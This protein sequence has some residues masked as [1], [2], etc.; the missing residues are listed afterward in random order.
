MAT[1]SSLP[2]KG[3]AGQITF[4]VACL[5]ALIWF[6]S[7]YV[8][9]V[10]NIPLG[11]DEYFQIHSASQ[12]ITFS[13]LSLTRIGDQADGRLRSWGSGRV[14]PNVAGARTWAQ[15][16]IGDAEFQ[17]ENPGKPF[18]TASFNCSL[19]TSDGTYRGIFS[20]RAFPYWAFVLPLMLFA[21]YFF[22]REYRNSAPALPLPRQKKQ[23]K[24]K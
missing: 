7:V 10:I 21:G 4:V 15:L 14:R 22:Y 9:N 24:K 1:E 8:Y 2:R 3:K 12:C 18:G 16:D 13:R 17:V 6:R 11:S 23:R 19:R 5:I 20:S